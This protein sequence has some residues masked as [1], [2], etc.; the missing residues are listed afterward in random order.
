LPASIAL[1]SASNNERSAGLGF[2]L[3]LD[4]ARV[5]DSVRAKLAALMG[6]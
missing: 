6:L 2:D 5:L 1:R 3:V 4:G